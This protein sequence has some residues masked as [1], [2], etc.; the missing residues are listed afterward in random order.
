MVPT[1][2]G[3][4]CP[5]NSSTSSLPGLYHLLFFYVN[6]SGEKKPYPPHVLLHDVGKFS[7]CLLHH[8]RGT[9]SSIG[10]K[11]NSGPVCFS[12]GYFTNCYIL[13]PQ[14][15]SFTFLVFS[16]RPSLIFLRSSF[17]LIV[18]P[19]V[20]QTKT[21]FLLSTIQNDPNRPLFQ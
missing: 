21:L 1:H 18:I 20:W 2:I 17:I 16:S 11:V 13:C 19:S 4:S 6:R 12:V 7:R 5:Q 14:T 3:F 15:L 10:P 8:T 9:E